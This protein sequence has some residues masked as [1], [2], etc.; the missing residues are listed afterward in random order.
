MREQI[1]KL[2]DLVEQQ[3]KKPAAR[4]L[5]VSGGKGGVGKTS[6]TVNFAIALSQRGK[7]VLII[8]ADFGLANIDVMLGVSVLNDLSSV[9]NGQKELRD[10]VA[11]G[12]QGVKFISGG[13]GVIDLIRLDEAKVLRLISRLGQLD[14][15]ADIILFDTSAGI[16][17]I[18]MRLVRSSNEAFIVTTPEPTAIMDAY[19]LIKTLDRY[20]E[21]PPLH[22]VV[23]MVA[24]S[25][26][27]KEML[28]GFT[29]VVGKNM[30]VQIDR[31]GYILRDPTVVQAI[32]AQVPFLV[33]FPGCMAAQNIQDIAARYLD[34][35]GTEH[36]GQGISQFLNRFLRRQSE[37][38]G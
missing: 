34:V 14:D 22:L 19:A 23:N 37:V 29:R 38:V 27:G 20:R 11:Q 33:G 7:R 18:V 10:I 8:D 21:T 2:R 3:K 36:K 35:P 30:D 32:R 16:S 31:M 17:D 26:E 1:S 12:H 28:Q 5:A 4:V 13:S 24:T 15:L 9:I 6:F 25:R